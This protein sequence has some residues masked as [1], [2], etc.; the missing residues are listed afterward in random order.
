MDSNAQTQ[1]GESAICSGH[2]Y[3]NLSVQ[4]IEDEVCCGGFGDAFL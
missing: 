2:C 1:K 3:T 4:D